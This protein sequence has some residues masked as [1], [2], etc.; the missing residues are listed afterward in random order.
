MS[1]DNLEAIEYRN[2]LMELVTDSGIEHKIFEDDFDFYIEIFLDENEV[3]SID[4]RFNYLEV[5]F[6]NMNFIMA[7][8]KKQEFIAVINGLM[9]NDF[10]VKEEFFF[11]LLIRKYLVFEGEYI[12][13]V[14]KS[15]FYF[16]VK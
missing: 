9:K 13:D 10:L 4:M 12:I 8:S 5:Y 15:I 11:K 3:F 1:M 14:Y 16:L 6:L 7:Y 2:I